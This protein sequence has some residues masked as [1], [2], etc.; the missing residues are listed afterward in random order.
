MA[1]DECTRLL[2]E[3]NS[4]KFCQIFSPPKNIYHQNPV[5]QNRSY[6]DQLYS[7]TKLYTEALEDPDIVEIEYNKRGKYS[8]TKIEKKFDVPIGFPNKS[9]YFPYPTCSVI[10]FEFNP[11][12][13][14]KF[15][16]DGKPT[17]L[18]RYTLSQDYTLQNGPGSVPQVHKQFYQIMPTVSL[19]DKTLP[20]METEQTPLPSIHIVTSPSAPVKCNNHP[21]PNQ[22]PANPIFSQ[23]GDGGQTQ[24]KGGAQGGDGG[25]T[26]NKGGAQGGDRG[27]AQNKGG[28][29]GGDRGQTPNK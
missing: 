12:N 10:K 6:L 23:S 19:T 28:A 4:H 26:Q 3:L 18:M 5:R 17:V 14:I 24:N 27:Q 11:A 8:G 15:Y 1:L 29:E 20:S 9:G 21:P 13:Q 16:S 25:Q 7:I 2:Q 22:P